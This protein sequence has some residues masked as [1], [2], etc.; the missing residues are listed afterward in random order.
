MGNGAERHRFDSAGDLY[1]V[2]SSAV[3][4]FHSSGVEV[5]AVENGPSHGVGVSGLAVDPTTDD[6]YV[7][8]GI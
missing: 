7:D 4:K 2:T 8:N 5:G 6:L 3:L 1:L